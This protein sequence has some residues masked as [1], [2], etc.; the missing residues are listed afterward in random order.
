MSTEIAWQLQS[1]NVNLGVVVEA[2]VTSSVHY[3][4]GNRRPKTPVHTSDPVRLDRLHQ[5]IHEALVLLGST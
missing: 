4:A 1:G 3:D 2:K 5:A